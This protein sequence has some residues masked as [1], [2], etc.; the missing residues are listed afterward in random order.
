MLFDKAALKMLRSSV[1]KRNDDTG[2]VKYFDAS[3]FP[4]L[5]KESFSFLS[6]RNEK[7]Q[8]YFYSYPGA[9]PD[10]LVVFDHGMGGGHR[11]Y[12]KEIE[13]LC[14]NSF[15]VFSYDH[16][17]CMES[18]GKDINGFAQSLGDL[19]SALKALKTTSRAGRRIFVIGHSWGGYAALNITFFHPE[20]ERV[21]SISG[22]RSVKAIVDQFTPGLMRLARKAVYNCERAS[23]PDYFDCDALNTLSASKSRFLLIHSSDDPL[24]DVKFHFYPLRDKFSGKENIRFVEVEGKGHD[25]HYTPKAVSVLSDFYAKYKLF[26]K[27]G[28]F[29][30]PE[31]KK[32][33]RDSFDWD[34]M[35][36]QDPGIW[37]QIL[38]FFSD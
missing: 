16:T 33:F 13:V 32:A 5:E 37:E 21:V 24:V 34:A 8:G 28:S 9:R 10:V 19:D 12:M 7:L 26:M 17:G 14:K 2:A 20:I 27:S 6:N 35:T 1:Y 22:F 31:A 4:G 29:G 3:D 11:S 18:E 30:D 38:S 36:E 15:E 23:N 25:P